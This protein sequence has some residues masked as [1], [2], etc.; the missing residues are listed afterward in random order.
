MVR[1]RSG[2]LRR[3]LGGARRSSGEPPAV[4]HPK[5]S[6]TIENLRKSQNAEALTN[7]EKTPFRKAFF[8]DGKGPLRAPAE[9]ARKSSKE[10]GEAARP[11]RRPKRAPKE[12]PAE[13]EE[14][15]TWDER[16]KSYDDPSATRM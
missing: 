7:F 14:A 10:L 2:P 11:P 13:P 9:G 12:P 6:P 1:G 4:E 15:D 3:E 8:K 5:L 16:L